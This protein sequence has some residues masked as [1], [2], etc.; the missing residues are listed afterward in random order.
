[1]PGSDDASRGPLN[2][3]AF[4]GT[5]IATLNKSLYRKFIYEV[6]THAR[7]AASGR[8]TSVDPTV[9][10][11]HSAQPQHQRPGTFGDLGNQ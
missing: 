2:I 8:P 1:M 11:Q 7:R 9:Q 3:V 4:L 6:Q 10:P 5:P